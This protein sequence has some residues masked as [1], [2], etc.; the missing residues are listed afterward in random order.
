MNANFSRATGGER[1]CDSGATTGL[2]SALGRTQSHQVAVVFFPFYCCDHYCK[3]GAKR[4]LNL[5]DF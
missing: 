4:V 3:A 2:K 1:Y 5:P